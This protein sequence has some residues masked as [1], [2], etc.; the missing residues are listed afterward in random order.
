MNV[1]DRFSG[2]ITEPA[3]AFQEVSR[4]KPTGLSFAV[5]AVTTVIALWV[6]SLKMG[7]GSFFA[8]ESRA[9]LILGGLIASILSQM[10]F[11]GFLNLAARIFKGTGSYWGVFSALAFAR[12]PLIFL[13]SGQLLGM[14][15]SHGG[16]IISGFIS[17]G[18]SL[19]NLVLSII[20]LRES[21]GFTTEKA[22]LTWLLALA[23]L[24]LIIVLPIILLIGI[25]ALQEAGQFM[26]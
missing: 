20:A 12:F 18:I 1:L 3:R 7:E 2:V 8:Q 4:E 21:Q 5:L 10:V 17:F 6:S 14:A 26:P 25:P 9:G 16:H 23:I 11:T 24:V 15:I 13:P 19:W 22:I